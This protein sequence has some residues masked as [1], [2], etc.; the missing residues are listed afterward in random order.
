[1]ASRFF[2]GGAARKPRLRSS[3]NAQDCG[4]ETQ[5]S[6][7]GWQESDERNRKSFDPRGERQPHRV[8]YSKRYLCEKNKR[9]GGHEENL[10]VA[11]SGKRFEG[12]LG[13]SSGKGPATGGSQGG[14]RE[15]EGEKN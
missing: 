12:V 6:A 7:K 2:K 3:K 11:E 10:D 5:S 14:M 8:P 9:T 15:K 1:M 13:V 4:K